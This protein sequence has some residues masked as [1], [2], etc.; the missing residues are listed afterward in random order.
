MSKKNKEQLLTPSQAAK[1]ICV[2]PETLRRYEEK[3]L[4][5]SSRTPGGHRRYKQ[6][7]IAILK[8][9]LKSAPNKPSSNKDKD[10][11]LLTQALSE[12]GIS[13][14]SLPEIKAVKEIF[15]DAYG[16]LAE[17]YVIPLQIQNQ[18]LALIA[19]IVNDKVSFQPYLYSAGWPTSFDFFKGNLTLSLAL[20]PALFINSKIQSEKDLRNLIIQRRRAAFC[21][22]FLV[23]VV[24][25]FL[26][27][28]FIESWT[29]MAINEK[30]VVL[31]FPI[32]LISL[33][34]I[35]M[36]ISDTG[37]TWKEAFKSYRI[38]PFGFFSF[39]NETKVHYINLRSYAAYRK[40]NIS[41]IS[42][43]EFN[44]EELNKNFW[45]LKYKPKI[46]RENKPNPFYK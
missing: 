27:L 13:T 36:K 3:G 9:N 31:L 12:I 6:E 5:T 17:A 25:W 24:L 43:L 28:K 22:T 11:A 37:T 29:S 4:I 40:A 44:E 23:T 2:H 18:Q 41:K 39:I 19:E 15:P 14:K 32:I 20:N 30:A 33:M 1:E 16:A 46:I 38:L 42:I 45:V 21:V 26:L 8:E 10:I 7:D 35:G 34:P